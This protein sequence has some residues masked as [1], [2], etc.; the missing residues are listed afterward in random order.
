[1]NDGPVKFNHDK[2]CIMDLSKDEHDAAML[3]IQTMRRTPP[4][5][6]YTVNEI[7]ELRRLIEHKYLFGSYLPPKEVPRMLTS[8][9]YYEKDKVNH[10]ESNVRTAMLA[11]HRAQD[12]IDSEAKS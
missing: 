7:D 6:S 3:A 2:Y 11:G 12:L 5:S 9:A 8:R 1:M 10:V 4:Q